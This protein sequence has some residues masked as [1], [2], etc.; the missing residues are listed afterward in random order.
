MAFEALGTAATVI[1]LVTTCLD[2]AKTLNDLHS[3][4]ERAPKT[5][6]TLSNEVWILS[7]NLS[8][9]GHL[10]QA[11][12]HNFETKFSATVSGGSN[13]AVPPDI[14]LR[15]AI[16]GSE[17]T[18][19][20]LRKRMEEFNAQVPSGHISGVI[21][22]KFL[23]S[24]SDIQESLETTRRLQQAIATLLTILQ[25]WVS[26]HFDNALTPMLKRTQAIIV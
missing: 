14:A 22:A 3:R 9:L 6:A 16:K 26:L 8:Q 24:E 25:S 11:D 19:S 7:T 17:T 5:I 1:G 13:A 21:R 15:N 4:F 2:V 10:I 20:L 12:P 18:M 23:W